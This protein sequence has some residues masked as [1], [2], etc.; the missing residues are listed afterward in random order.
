MFSG[1]CSKKRLCNAL[2]LAF[3]CGLKMWK[4]TL[5][6]HTAQSAAHSRTYWFADQH[7]F[8]AFVQGI[9]C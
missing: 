3:V 2:I 1:R 6:G 9:S 5:L 4:W 8:G 7:I